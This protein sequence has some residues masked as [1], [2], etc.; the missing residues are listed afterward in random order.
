MSRG[1]GRT[2]DAAILALLLWLY[3]RRFRES[4]GAEMVAT[5]LERRRSHTK[6]GQPH[7]AF[8]VLRTWVETLIEVPLAWGDAWNTD[9]LAGPPARQPRRGD[10]TMMHLLYESRLAARALLARHRGFTALSVLTLAL[11]LGATIAIFSVV[12]GV[13][14]APLPYGDPDRMVFVHQGRHSEAWNQFTGPAFGELRER[15]GSFEALAA[16]DDYRAEGRDLTGGERAERLAILRVGSGFFEALGVAPLLGRTFERAEEIPPGAAERD[17]DRFAMITTPAQPVAVISHS[18]WLRHFSGDPAALGQRLELDREPYEVVG[19]MP[20]GIGGHAGGTPDV[21]LPL[22]L[23]P[24]G[25]NTRGNH[26]LSVVGRLAEGV[27]L[28]RARGELEAVA[29]T[30]QQTYPEEARRFEF[31]I[32]PLEQAVVG[33]SRPLL[34]LLMAAVAAMLAIACINVANLFLTRGLARQRELG[35]RAAL[36]AG[37]RRLF[38]HALIASL[39]V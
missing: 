24:G 28:D 21:W 2:P 34:G 3:P 27:T 29:H 18:F 25:L 7:L 30:L 4:L 38:G 17:A 14:L 26:Y 31:E 37:R 22:D 20:P 8:W 32:A 16:Y 13:L 5:Y 19:V 15:M 23:A 9:A 33:P 12:H 36:G 10:S 1:P 39:L 35:L 11:G 6:R